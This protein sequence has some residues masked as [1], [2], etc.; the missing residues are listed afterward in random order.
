MGHLVISRQGGEGVSIG[1]THVKVVR[2]RGKRA[3]LLITANDSIPITRDEFLLRRESP[4]KEP[5]GD[6]PLARIARKGKSVPSI[7][8]TMP[9]K[10]GKAPSP[11][12]ITEVLRT[13]LGDTEGRVAGVTCVSKGGCEYDDVPDGYYGPGKYC[14]CFA[15]GDETKP[16]VSVN[17]EVTE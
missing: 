13:K 3:T 14:V 4:A 8:L 11:W 7:E 5:S 16:V 2:V 10:D 15:P 6:A 9:A 1:D 12:E 17:L